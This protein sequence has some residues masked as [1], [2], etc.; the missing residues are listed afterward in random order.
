MNIAVCFSGQLRS[1]DFTYKNISKFL[2]ENFENYKIFA[3]IPEN[4]DINQKFT[5]YFTNSIYII[6]KDPKIKETKLKNKQ[7]ESVKNKNRF[8]SLKKAKIAH[9]QQLYGIFKSNQLKKDYEKNNCVT[10]D[11][12]LRCRSDIKFYDSSLDLS[13]MEN[14]YL[15]TPHFH[16]WGGINDR[17]VISSSKNMDIFSNLFNHIKKNEV[18]GFNAESIFSTYLENENIEIKE[19]N[20]VKFNRIRSN[21]SELKDF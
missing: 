3:H 5:D 18:D 13:K 2:N 11:W 16:K 19:L 4:K 10:F 7:F 1:L 15:Y 9:M 20:S 14:R 6:E 21:G 17:F 12:V 8:N